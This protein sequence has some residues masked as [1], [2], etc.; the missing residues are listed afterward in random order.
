MKEIC[1]PAKTIQSNPNPIS[2][3]P[4]IYMLTSLHEYRLA[5]RA[6]ISRVGLAKTTTRRPNEIIGI[7]TIFPNQYKIAVTAQGHTNLRGH[8]ENSLR[9]I[10]ARRRRQ[11]LLRQ[12]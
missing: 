6:Q 8:P 2:L 7:K 9:F 4:S 5:S 12:V 1:V 3:P 10:T 11:E